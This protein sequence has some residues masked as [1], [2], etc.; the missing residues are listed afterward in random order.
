MYFAIRVAV[1]SA[2]MIGFYVTRGFGSQ[3]ETFVLAFA[4]ALAAQAVALAVK[5]IVG[6][7][8]RTGRAIALL[9]ACAIVV[10]AAIA[11]ITVG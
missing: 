5:L 7:Q 1:A 3:R 9:A 2:I 4:A 11:S 10:A 8:P 6:D